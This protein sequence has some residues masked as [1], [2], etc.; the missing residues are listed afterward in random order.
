MNYIDEII[1]Y[2]PINAQEIEDKKL[3][4]DLYDK[5]K[6]ELL[7][8]ECKVA[9]MSASA[10][11]TNKDKTKVLMNYHNLYQN[12]G[13]L[14]GHADGGNDMLKVIIKEIYE[15]S[16]LK[17]IKLLYDN[18]ISLEI[19]PVSYHIKKGSFVSSH[20]HLNVTYL[21]ETDDTLSLTINP[22]ENSGLKWVLIEDSINETKEEIMKPIY[23]KLNDRI[24]NLK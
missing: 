21:F 1:N 22:S 10:W 6:D 9:H 7:Y 3:I 13:W 23:K 2:N 5:Y 15:E 4:L 14:G 18:I 12:W 20:L 16:G 24:H 8:R 11:I 17:D 19:L